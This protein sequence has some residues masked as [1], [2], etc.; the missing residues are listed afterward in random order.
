MKLRQL[1]QRHQLRFIIALVVMTNCTRYERNLF[2]DYLN[3]SYKRSFPIV[4]IEIH[5]REKSTGLREICL[6]NNVS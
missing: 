1:Y 3:I 4:A 5:I 6:Q 2:I